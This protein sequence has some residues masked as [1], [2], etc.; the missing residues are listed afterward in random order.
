MFYILQKSV[1]D[2]RTQQNVVTDVGVSRDISKLKGWSGRDQWYEV[3]GDFHTNDEPLGYVN[4]KFTITRRSAEDV[5]GWLMCNYD[6]EG[7]KWL[8]KELVELLQ[9]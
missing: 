1:Y 6:K 9:S 7:R 5:V 2:R 4:I 8:E 3:G